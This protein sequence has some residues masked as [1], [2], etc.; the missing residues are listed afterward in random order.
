MKMFNFQGFERAIVHRPILTQD[1]P[2]RNMRVQQNKFFVFSKRGNQPFCAKSI[3]FT[4]KIE[5]IF[6]EPFRIL[7]LRF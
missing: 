7:S 4:Q 1:I 3:H 5:Y 2:R 6:K